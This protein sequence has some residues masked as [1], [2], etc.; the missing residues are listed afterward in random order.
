[1]SNEKLSKESQNPPL[2][3]GDVRRSFSKMDMEICWN[4]ARSKRFDTGVT[5]Y[6][7]FDSWYKKYVKKT[8]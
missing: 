7:D 4:N 8:K 5:M 3:K 6:N 2:R 1:M